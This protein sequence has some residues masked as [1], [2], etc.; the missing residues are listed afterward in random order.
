MLNSVNKLRDIPSNYLQIC[1]K[2][3]ESN[4]HLLLENPTSTAL[5]TRLVDLN[6]L[7]EATRLL[8][9]A[10]PEREAVWWACRCVAH[11]VPLAGVPG[12]Q[13]AALVAAENWVR[14]PNDQM[15]LQAHLAAA[16]AGYRTPAAWAAGAAFAS[17]LPVSWPRRTGRKV[18]RAVALAATHDGTAHQPERLRQFIASGRDIAAGGAG[19]LTP[20]AE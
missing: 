12:E 16:N 5:L 6:L 14:Q 3:T 15:R 1:L 2:M 13:S 11:A 4:E 8:S 9:Y 19:R 20:A 18:A 10:L 7:P 17:P